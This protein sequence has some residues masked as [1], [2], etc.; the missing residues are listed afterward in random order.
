ME[1]YE[2]LKS[3]HEKVKKLL[4]KLVSSSE[5]G[6]PEWKSLVSEIRDELIPHSRAEE[7]VFYNS[8]RESDQTA[9]LARH[10]YMEHME[11]ESILRALQVMSAVDV[12]WKALALKLKTDLENHVAEEEGEMFTA[13]KKIFTHDDAIAMEK[14]FQAMKPAIKDENFM[15]TTVDL[16]ANMMPQKFSSSFKNF[17]KN[18]GAD[19]R[20]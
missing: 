3:D 15:Q 7:A 5:A 2:A 4:I 8:L 12:N 19:K 20:I 16:V 10:A 11:A 14:A 1:I 17:S 18:K 9:E 13:A 6:T